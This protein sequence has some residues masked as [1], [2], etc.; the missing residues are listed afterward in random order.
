MKTVADEHFSAVDDSVRKH[1]ACVGTKP[2]RTK[3]PR[4]R[5]ETGFV[6][7]SFAANPKQHRLSHANGL[8]ELTHREV[9][10]NPAD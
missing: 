1:F 4:R 7:V 9:H 8:T 2:L 3:A 5:M 6:S 10:F